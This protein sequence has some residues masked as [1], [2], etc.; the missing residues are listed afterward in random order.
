[1]NAFRSAA[2]VLFTCTAAA[3]G[4]LFAGHAPTPTAACTPEAIA[5]DTPVPLVVHE[6]GTFTSFSGSDGLTVGFVPDNT[7]LP[8]FVYVQVGENS[9][10]GRLGQG[11][12]V[13]METPVMYFYTDRPMRASVRV[14]FP[15]GWITE[16]YPFAASA[17]NSKGGRPGSTAQ[18]I[19]WDVRLS[20]GEAMSFPRGND[21]N[22]YYRARETDAAPLQVEIPAEA[23]RQNGDLRGGTVVQREKFL[24]YRGVGTFPTPVSVR[25][26]G[27]GR[28][29]VRNADAGRVDGV[30]LVHVHDGRIGFRVVGELSPG[31][32]TVATI[33]AAE[34]S[35]GELA[36]VLVRNL[37]ATG[38]YEAEARA[39][40]RTWEKAWFREE[41]TR[42]LYLVP[43]A[44]TDELL[45]LKMDPKPTEVV[46]VLVGRHDFLTPELEAAA[47]RLVER[48]RAARAEVDASEAEIRK[49]GRFSYEA[50][51][52]SEKRL[53]NRA[54]K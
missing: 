10:G 2:A 27:G 3:A 42:V 51:Q 15:R 43:R 23:S 40:V 28:V 11:G 1:M 21:D 49:I 8:E 20:P 30:V 4:L 25:A 12:T 6:W 7:D 36:E 47:D 48:N 22:H 39:M 9:K 45:P 37:T 29:R 35:S 54:Q 50:R 38:L 41:G 24:F 13:S 44:R 46:R 19:R 31:A 34:T 5:A 14:D 16:W 26:I 53:D 52:Q 33:P 17:P 18:S 32:E